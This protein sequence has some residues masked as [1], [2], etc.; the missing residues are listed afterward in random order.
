MEIDLAELGTMHPALPTDLAIFL[1][2]QGA[3]A[4]QRSGH[5][6]GDGLELHIQRVPQIVILDW[7]RADLRVIDKHDRD[8]ITEFGAE[9]VALGIASKLRSWKVIRRLQKGERAD[10]LLEDLRSQKSTEIALEVSGV[11]TGNIA[12]R[13][14]EKLSQVS[15][16]DE[17]DEKWACV[18]GFEKPVSSLHRSKRSRRGN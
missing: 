2:G 8:R 16:S 15:K 12:M 5:E 17:G 7:S 11:T 10:W 4:L 6:P 13:L 9:A 1:S 18:V 3:L 14:S